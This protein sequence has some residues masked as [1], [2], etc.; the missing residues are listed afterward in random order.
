MATDFAEGLASVTLPDGTPIDINARG[1]IVLRPRLKGAF[2]FWAFSEGLALVTFSGV[3]GPGFR[4]GYLDKTGKLAIRPFGAAQAEQCKNGLA[5]VS[6]T[7][8]TEENTWMNAGAPSGA[9]LRA[10]TPA[11]VCAPDG[12]GTL[13]PKPGVIT[14]GTPRMD[15]PDRVSAVKS[16]PRPM[17]GLFSCPPPPTFPR[18]D[19]A[20]QAFH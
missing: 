14:N 5:Y 6:A 2:N 20:A 13:P 3:D 1:N 15:V 10:I 16:A 8:E 19:A 4:Y 17:T 9:P 11:A 12:A 18:N 7:S